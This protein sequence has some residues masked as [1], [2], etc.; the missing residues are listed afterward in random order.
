MK[1]KSIIVLLIAIPLIIGAIVIL[2]FNHETEQE[3]QERVRLAMEKVKENPAV[4]NQIDNQ[5][6]SKGYKIAEGASL[7]F[8]RDDDL[9]VLIK[10]SQKENDENYYE[11]EKEIK[12]IVNK[13]LKN[14]NLADLNLSVRVEATEF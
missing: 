7:E 5:L 2:N 8:N 13:I 10:I 4:L 1:R 14:S 3:L 11:T 12:N 9:A 6:K